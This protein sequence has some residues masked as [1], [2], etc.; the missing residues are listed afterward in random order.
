M[1]CKNCSSINI[2][3][4]KTRGDCFCLDCGYVLEEN[5]VVND[6]AFE[7]SKVVGTFVNNNVS[8]NK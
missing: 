8:S 3:T 7:E 5:M 6:V 4:D 1:K 2:E